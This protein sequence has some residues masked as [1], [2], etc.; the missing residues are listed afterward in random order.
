MTWTD[1]KNRR[2][3]ELIDKEID[4]TLS[5]TEAKELEVLQS[6]ML[7]YRQ[8][9]APLPL[10]K[11]RAIRQELMTDSR[12]LNKSQPLTSKAM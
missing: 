1:Q 7:A 2:R 10:D 12:Y 4:E 3:C 6:E 5:E 8:K 11:V 9:V